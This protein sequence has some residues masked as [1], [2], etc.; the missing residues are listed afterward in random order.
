LRYSFI[1]CFPRIYI[2]PGVFLLLP[3]ALLAIPLRL[4]FSWIVAAGIHEL[5]HILAVYLLKGHITKIRIGVGG[6]VI[7]GDNLG[8]LRNCICVIAGPLFGAI[9]LLFARYIPRIGLIS[10]LLSA[11]NLLPFWPLD[12]GRILAFC[13]E[14]HYFLRKV[15]PTIE[16]SVRMCLIVSAVYFKTSLPLFPLI[17]PLRE[18]YL[19]NRMKRGYNS[20]TIKVR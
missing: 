6:A 18:K 16:L 14:K 2:D 1:Q 3:F 8:V 20:A 7:A 11:Y 9:P 19:A 17:L 13:G 15:I 12:G 10:L 5:G 4:L